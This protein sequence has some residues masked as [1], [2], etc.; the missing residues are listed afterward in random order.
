MKIMAKEIKAAA[1]VDAISASVAVPSVEVDETGAPIDVTIVTVTKGKLPPEEKTAFQGSLAGKFGMVAASLKAA[2]T[3]VLTAS[4]LDPSEYAIPTKAAFAEAGGNAPKE[5]E[6]F[7]DLSTEEQAEMSE[8]LGHFAEDVAEYRDAESKS[9]A[10]T[11]KV[12]KAFAEIMS[13][14]PTKKREGIFRTYCAETAV[15]AKAEKWP[16]ADELSAVADI[17]TSKNVPGE[18]KFFASIPD[19]L[20]ALMPE[21]KNGPKAA[22]AWINGLRS[23]LANALVETVKVSE[24]QESLTVAFWDAAESVKLG[25][26]SDASAMLLQLHLDNLPSG[27]LFDLD[28][29]GK[30][31]PAKAVA[32]AKGYVSQS[33]FGAEGSDELLKAFCNAFNGYRTAAEKEADKEAKAK[34]APLATRDFASL[35][36]AEVALHLFRILAGRIDESTEATLEATTAD[37]DAIVQALADHVASVADGSMT[38]ADIVNPKS[39]APESEDDAESDADAI[40]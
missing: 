18:L 2:I 30:L 35:P 6:T 26:M 13:R 32:P 20:L 15:K 33:L 4:G 3:S 37:C 21:G 16:N 23:D 25:A 11:R 22:Q 39:E 12:A 31:S 7:A 34:V 1:F 38:V 10:A 28:A 24:E 36:V 9:R 8:T 19:S 27:G 5:A 17:V 40:A 29:S 14:F